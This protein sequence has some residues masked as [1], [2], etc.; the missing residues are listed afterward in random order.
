MGDEETI[1]GFGRNATQDVIITAEEIDKYLS[2]PRKRQLKV[3]VEI[4]NGFKSMDEIRCPTCKS[5]N[6]RILHNQD[7][8]YYCDDCYHC[9]GK[10]TTECPSCV[11]GIIYH[12]TTFHSECEDCNGTGRVPKPEEG[13]E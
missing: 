12:G 6:I 2:K 11:S 3:I 5:R 1:W 8:R 4:I 7:H 9:W 10:D 13:S